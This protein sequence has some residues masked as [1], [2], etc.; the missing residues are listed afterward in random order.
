MILCVNHPQ[1]KVDHYGAEQSQG[2]NGGS[3]AII[4]STLASLA[5]TLGSPVEGEQGVDHGSHGD[6]GEQAC[7]DAADGV[8]KVQQ[9]DSQT[10]EDDGEI[11]P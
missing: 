7:G 10:T 4:E 8:S 1:D 11:E 9:T 2:E 6:H 5:D 3:D